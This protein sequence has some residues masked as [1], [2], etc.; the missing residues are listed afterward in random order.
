MNVR[1][2]WQDL[3]GE[4]WWFLQGPYKPKQ[5]WSRWGKT[6]HLESIQQGIYPEHYWILKHIKR[7][8]P[9]TLLE[10]GCGFGRNIKFLAKHYQYPL[11]VTAT[12]ISPSMIKNA[13]IF[14][15][16][17]SFGK[18]KPELKVADIV[19]L[20]FAKA[21][22]DIVLIHSVINYVQ[23][24]NFEKALKQSL[25][26]TKKYLILS[27]EHFA[28]IKRNRQGF[29]KANKFTFAYD[30]QTA[31]GA[32]NCKIVDYKRVDKTGMDCFLIE[33]SEH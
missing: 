32:L 14:L 22:F 1:K 3:R 18:Y 19:N 23:P 30:Y 29:A 10:I 20:P 17:V 13:K 9:K 31:L 2:L 25:K 4:I 8:K 24:P 12:D 6:F 21:S 11:K 5:F 27:E 16:D 15:E 26:I 33:K 7:L 28:D